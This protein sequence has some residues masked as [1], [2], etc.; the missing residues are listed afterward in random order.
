MWDSVFWNEDNYWPD[1]TTKT[2]NE[3]V[4]K[5]DAE[6]KK[7]LTDMFQKAGN[8]ISKSWADVPRISSTISKKMATDS[9]SF[10][11]L[12]IAKEDAEKLLQESKNYVQWDGEKFAP[13][14]I[15]L[16]KINLDKFRDSQSFQ[17]RK[18]D[19]RYTT[20]D[21]SAAIKI[22]EHAELTVTDTDE[23]KNLEDQLKGL[24]RER[25]NI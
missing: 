25:R 6:T 10:G 14:P 12:K 3:I 8:S 1:K 23:Q 24:K 21:L 22:M 18:V 2:L 4:K 5:L 15:Q 11:Q 13:K 7:K 19:V 17:D 20:A 16:S 9:D